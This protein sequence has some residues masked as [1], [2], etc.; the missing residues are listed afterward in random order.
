MLELML[1]I[2]IN[3]FNQIIHFIIFFNQMF[4]STYSIFYDH[5]IHYLCYSYLNDSHFKLVSIF[6]DIFANILL[7]EVTQISLK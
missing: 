1:K 6:K 4:L 7:C 2:L 3:Y 5:L